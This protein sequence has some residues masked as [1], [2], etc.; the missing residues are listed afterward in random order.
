MSGAT[1]RAYITTSDGVRL[2]TEESG[3]GDPIIFAHE[4]AGHHLSWETQVR[5]FSRRYRCITYQAR[6]WPPSDVPTSVDSYSQA[7][8]ADD[9][10]DV[11]AALGIAKAHVVGL[12]M[13]ATAAIEF[14]IRHPGKGMS[15]AA[16]GAGTG[17]TRDTATLARFRGEAAQM[18]ELIERKGIA[19][20]GEIYLSGPSRVQ[21]LAKDPRGYAEFKQ[22]FIEGAS[23]GRA[24]TMRGIQARR[25]PF[26]DREDELRAIRDPVL[27]ICGDEDDATLDVSVFMKRTIPRSGLMVFPKTGHGINLE[28]PAG[29]NAVVGDFIQAVERD[30]WPANVSTAGKGFA[31]FPKT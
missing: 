26:F 28:E 21:L 16:A 3:A 1:K 19:A 11:M 9:I 18:A 14:A 12:S 17:S 15:I 22:Q 2:Y 31:M 25:V 5:Y 6:G 27:I 8:A 7:R 4:F 20:L 30:R 23:T 29:F 24:L 13:G 10:A